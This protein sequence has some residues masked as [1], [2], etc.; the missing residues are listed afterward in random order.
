M[1]RHLDHFGGDQNVSV[2]HTALILRL[3][4]GGHNCLS[5]EEK[6][7]FCPLFQTW[8]ADVEFTCGFASPRS[9]N[10]TTKSTTCESKLNVKAANDTSRLASSSSV[11][12]SRI[13]CPLIIS[14]VDQLDYHLSINRET[15]YSSGQP[16]HPR[17][18]VRAIVLHGGGRGKRNEEL[19]GVVA[20]VL[21]RGLRHRHLEEGS[22]LRS[23]SWATNY[24]EG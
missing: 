16:D 7:F 20:Q 22:T 8:H 1:L 14:L 5:D 21:H 19:G 2:R 24:E 9:E 15:G 23:S 13:F 4:H 18:G 6:F 10:G 12:S 3:A 11:A 17:G